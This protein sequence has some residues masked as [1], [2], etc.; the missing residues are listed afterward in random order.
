MSAEII[1]AEWPKNGRETMRVRLDSFKDQAVIDC[2]AWYPGN[3][4]RLRPGRGGLTVSIRHLPSL[5]NA[6]AKAMETAIAAGLIVE[7]SPDAQDS[8]TQ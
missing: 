1:I 7:Y 4:G 3:D 8:P 5:A 6:L 2:R